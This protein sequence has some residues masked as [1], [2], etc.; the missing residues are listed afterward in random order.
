MSEGSYRAGYS[1][2]DCLNENDLHES[3][4]KNC[5]KCGSSMTSDVEIIADERSYGDVMD[6]DSELGQSASRIWTCPTCQHT[7]EDYLGFSG[8][9][10][11]R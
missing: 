1:V 4:E 5:P 11:L 10:I 8:S 9:G 7:E 2:S 6:G 3:V